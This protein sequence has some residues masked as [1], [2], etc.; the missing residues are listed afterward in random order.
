MAC[1]ALALVFVLWA[2][3]GS[4]WESLAWGGVLIAAGWPVYLMARRAAA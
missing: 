2:F 1:T 3:Y 4:G